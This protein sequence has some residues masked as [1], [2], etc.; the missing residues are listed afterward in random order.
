MYLCQQST[1]CNVKRVTG[2]KSAMNDW[3]QLFDSTKPFGVFKLIVLVLDLQLH[4]FNSVLL[5]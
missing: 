3:T 4:C 2:V 5:L 1:L